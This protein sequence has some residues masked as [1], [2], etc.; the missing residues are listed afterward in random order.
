MLLIFVLFY[1]KIFDEN[2]I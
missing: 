2:Q 1:L